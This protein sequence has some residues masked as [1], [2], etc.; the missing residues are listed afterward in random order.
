MIRG[1]L[2]D[3]DGV[4]VDTAKFHFLAWQRMAGELGIAFGHDENEQL[5]GVSRRASLEK[6]L[7]WGGQTL[8]EPEMERWMATKNAWYLEYVATMTSADVLPGATEFLR[9]AREAG[10][11]IALGSASKNAL[12]ILELVGILNLFDATVDGNDVT[13]SKPDP[14]VFLEGARK[15]NLQ[16]HE[17]LVVEDAAA[18]IE[19]ALCAGML[20]LGL[21]TPEALPQAHR[22]LP[23]L[24]GQDPRSLVADLEARAAAIAHAGAEGAAAERLAASAHAAAATHFPAVGAETPNTHLP[25]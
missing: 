19:A 7:A 20:A 1:F 4:L 11:R 2:F 24:Q 25:S 6:I 5:K 17:C 14:S 12:P 21:G 9:S 8:P 13:A 18:G 3:L 15:L 22:V 23:D 10:Y 16:P